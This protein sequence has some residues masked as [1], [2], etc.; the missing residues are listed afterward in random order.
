LSILAPIVCAWSLLGSGSA[1]AESVDSE[2]LLLVDVSNGGLKKGEF[3]RLMS[4]YADALTS[5]AV[6]DSIAS[7]RTGKIAVSLSFYGVKD[8]GSSAGVA[9]MAISN[10]VEAEAFASRLRSLSQPKGGNYSYQDALVQGLSSIGDE[11]G[12]VDNGFSS[13]LQIIEV[14][15]ST[16]PKGNSGDVAAASVAALGRGVDV[17]NATVVGKKADQLESFYA[18]HVIGG[19]VGGMSAL[20]SVSAVDEGLSSIL[21]SQIDRSVGAA[22]IAAVPEPSSAML[23]ISSLGFLLIFA[24][25]RVA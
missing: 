19:S 11:V 3:N 8:S 22:G 21:S 18:D 23:L 2:L 20:V 6:L 16:K 12:G 1:T 24:R 13:A 5:D 14:G 25:R 7:G 15:G 10:R 4:G 17:I 9:W